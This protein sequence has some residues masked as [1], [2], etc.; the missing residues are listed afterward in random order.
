M[1]CLINI[2]LIP[3]AQLPESYMVVLKLYSM[4]LELAVSTNEC[5]VNER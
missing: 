4:A 1:A 3:K 5:S 2:I